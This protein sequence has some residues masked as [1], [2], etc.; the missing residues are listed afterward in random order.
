MGGAYERYMTL[1]NAFLDEGWEVH[2]ISPRGFS[3]INR[4][5]L[6][7]H[8]TFG[9]HLYPHFLAFYIQ[10]FFIMLSI[11]R[12]NDIDIILAFS[13]FEAIMGVIFKFFNKKSKLVTCFRADSIS[14]YEHFPD[15]IKKSFNLNF[16]KFIEKIVV[17][18]SDLV[19]FLS[20]KNKKD[21]LKRLNYTGNENKV[22]VVYNGITPRLRSLSSHDII[23]Y[24]DNIVIGF[25]GGLYDGKGLNYLI[26]A[27]YNIKK[28]LPSSILVIVGDGPDKHK[29][30]RTVKELNLEDNVIFTGYKTNPF[31]YIK[32]F[33]LMV[34]PSLS[35]A[36]GIVI[37]E[38]LYV[39]T[40]VF[41]SNV[42]GI[43]EVLKYEELIFDLKTDDLENNII[44]F[45]NNKKSHE[46]V[47][48]F[49]E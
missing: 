10:T 8:E 47:L 25:V 32:G 14:N 27:F 22:K 6:I 41:G 36:F 33:D 38:A 21:I 31:P 4:E 46:N 30:I 49:T 23:R 16:I 34:V 13:A 17:N 40:P 7:H 18:K 39:G 19:I 24:S 42:G 48:E 35:E 3:N 28:S 37:F 9:L 29:F 26:N 15:S 1:I 45:F 44:N 2:H 5:S 12:K 20:K 43:P 11:N